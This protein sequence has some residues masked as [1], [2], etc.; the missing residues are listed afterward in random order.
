MQREVMEQL[1]EKGESAFD[2]RRLAAGLT[3]FGMGLFKKVALADAIASYADSVFGAVAGG[4]TV[5]Q[6]IAWIGALCYTLQLYFDFSGYSDMAIGLAFVFGI[7]LP[8]NFDSPFKA[9]NISDF[10]RRWHMTMTRFFT[11]YVYSGL[12]MRGMRKAMGEGGGAKYR[13]LQAA[14]IPSILTFL[15]AGVWHGAGYT[16]VVYGLLHGCAIATCLAWREFSSIR[17][18]AAAN[19]LLTMLVVVSGLVIFRSP[20]MHTAGS[21]L[22]S[23]A[24]L[25]GN[26]I[27][28]TA[29]IDLGRAVSWIVLLGAIVLLLP[30][31][32]Q[33]LHKEWVSSDTKPANIAADAGLLAWRPA[34]TGALAMGGAFA[35]ALT[36]IGA[37]TGFLYYQF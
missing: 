25:G 12:A 9:T 27:Q 24:G 11:N 31:T 7:R 21:L 1:G 6:S 26:A 20:D 29:G 14:A 23:M 22:A 4:A 28:S 15:I 34:F 16:F 19:W 2:P 18:P 8:I 36:S 10:W 5:D 17:L 3:M 30:N 37:G 13:F 33:I 35:V 32:Q